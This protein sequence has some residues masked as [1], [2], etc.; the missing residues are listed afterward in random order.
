MK[1][2]IAYGSNLN[3]AQMKDRCPDAVYIGNGY[4]KNWELIYRGS[5]TGA[6][7]T[8]RPAKG[9]IVPIG[10]WAISRRDEE[11]L[12]GYEGYPVFYHKKTLKVHGNDTV[13]KGMV[14]VMDE[15]RKVGRPSS[16]YIDVVC[17]GYMDCDL[18]GRFLMDSLRTNWLELYD[19]KKGR[20]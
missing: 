20:G 3:M 10:L 16:H 1:Y 14:Y 6:Y 8:I 7:A 12:D 17:E 2:Y 18:D 15:N 11:K 13:K 9:K 5:K 19:K 4:L